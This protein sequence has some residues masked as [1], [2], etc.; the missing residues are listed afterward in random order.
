V[1]HSNDNN[2]SNCYV[3]DSLRL[4][5]LFRVPSHDLRE[6]LFNPDEQYVRALYVDSDNWVSPYQSIVWD[7]GANND[8]I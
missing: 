5:R 2:R 8:L 4:D 6:N 3:L 7:T 1:S